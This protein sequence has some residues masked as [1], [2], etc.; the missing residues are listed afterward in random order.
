MKGWAFV[1]AI[2]VALALAGCREE[3][4]AEPAPAPS[5][6]PPSLMPPSAATPAVEPSAPEAPSAPV[7]LHDP[8]LP[9]DAVLSVTFRRTGNPEPL[10]LS[11]YLESRVSDWLVPV[12]A[13]GLTDATVRSTL[14]A[15]GATAADVR[16]AVLSVFGDGPEFAL[17]CGVAHDASQLPQALERASDAPWSELRT[18]DAPAWLHPRGALAAASVDGSVV[19]LAS[20]EERLFR[21]VALYRT[22]AGAVREPLPLAADATLVLYAPDAVAVCGFADA[23]LPAALARLL[24]DGE[25]LVGR[26]GSL[27]CAYAGGTEDARLEIRL[28]MAA[29]A[30]AAALAVSLGT[31]VPLVSG[32]DAPLAAERPR[33]ARLLAGLSV[34]AEANAVVCRWPLGGGR[35]EEL[36]RI[37]SEARSSAG[38]VR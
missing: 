36:V 33:A 2:A 16:W 32:A 31:L 21:Q 24:P 11:A 19:L 12:V 14:A 38:S 8:S 25:R 29:A 28:R 20:S 26:A 3:R 4:S 1:R 22:G 9:A 15:A 23:A 34:G 27:S 10:G 17:A 7:R 35:A 5:D 18:M 6:P 30:D 13:N 37:L